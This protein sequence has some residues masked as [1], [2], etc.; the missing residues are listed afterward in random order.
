[1][2]ASKMFINMVFKS[3]SVRANKTLIILLS[4]IVS[5]SIVFAFS[6]IYFDI[7]T[8]MSK[9]LRV[10]GANFFIGKKKINEKDNISL[11][12]YNKAL[13]FI[14][15]NKIVGATPLVYGLVRLDLGNAVLAGIDF[16]EAKKINPFWQVEGLWVSVDFDDKNCMIGKTLAKSMELSIGSVVTVKNDKTGFGQKLT[17]KG[18]IDSGQSEDNQIF[19][20][21]KFASKILGIK[22]SFNHA[23]LSILCDGDSIDKLAQSINQNIKTIKAKPIRK[24]SHSEGKI[25]DKIKGLMAIIAF[26][27]LVITTLC[28]NATLI[29]S[30][31]E[32]SME[33]G[34]Q[35]AIG[36]K[37]R[38]IVNQFLMENSIIT[39][40]GIILGSI[41]GYFLAQIM[42]KAIFDSSIEIRAWVIPITFFISFLASMFA[43]ML[44]IKKVLQIAPAK[45]LRDE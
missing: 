39:I 18:I 44:P 21:F 4:V 15:S 13:G 26:M 24:V 27:I 34:L 6:S 35:K 9:E 22:E 43:A 11:S 7:N 28:V 12:E 14:D 36:A 10:F 33:I 23:M 38:D 2:V 41:L 3:I 16:K 1:M 17:I 40:V 29:S 32:R 5:A 8:K 20:N 42:G 31:D 37:N 45:V 30:I 25:L 19:V